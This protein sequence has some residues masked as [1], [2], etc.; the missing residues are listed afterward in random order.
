MDVNIFSQFREND[1]IC[2]EKNFT[3]AYRL[4]V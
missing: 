1:V 4:P 3:Q 2:I